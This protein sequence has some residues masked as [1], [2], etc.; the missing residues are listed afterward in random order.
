MNVHTGRASRHALLS[1]LR[2]DPDRV[3]R[4]P[5]AWVLLGVNLFTILIALGEGWRLSELLWIYWGQSVI[6]GAFHVARILKLRRFSTR[7]FRINGQAVAPT[8]AVR[9]Q[10]AV[11]FAAHFGFFHFVYLMFIGSLSSGQAVPAA[12]ILVC[13][14]AFLANHAFS[15]RHNLAGDAAR[16]RNI[17]TLMFLPYGRVV[18]MHL[19]LLFAGPLAKS[20]A[21][22]VFFLLLKS[23][24]D[25]V[26]HLAEHGLTRDA[27]AQPQK[28][29][30]A[31]QQVGVVEDQHQ[32]GQPDGAGRRQV[33]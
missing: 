25:V 3:R 17:G 21:A 5:S 13:L 1:S 20:P 11:F 2:L 22:L 4:D 33:G 10:T 30:V 19:T 24:A 32:S 29:P 31:A 7:G 15:F 9:R 28:V 8:P 27:L 6:I 23:A 18:P 16:V 26:M 12:P 14:A